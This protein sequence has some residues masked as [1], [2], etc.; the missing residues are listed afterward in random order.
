MVGN[1]IALD[2]NVTE[3]NLLPNSVNPTR[4]QSH[5]VKAAKA[6]GELERLFLKRLSHKHHQASLLA[7]KSEDH[8]LRIY[9]SIGEELILMRLSDAVESLAGAD[10]MQTHRSWW[11]ARHTI[12]DVQRANKVNCFCMQ[13]RI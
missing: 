5:D 1:R 9:T 13:A 2:L 4:H 7:I 8:Y 6:V 12:K 3:T 10:G 11:V